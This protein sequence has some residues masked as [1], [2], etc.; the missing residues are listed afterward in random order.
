MAG[1]VVYHMRQLALV[2]GLYLKGKRN[3]FLFM[4]NMRMFPLYSGWGKSQNEF[5]IWRTTIISCK[6]RWARK[7]GC[8][9]L[10]ITHFSGFISHFKWKHES[11]LLHSRLHVRDE[12]MRLTRSPHCQLRECPCY[13][14][15]L[16]LTSTN[17]S[18]QFFCLQSRP[19]LA[20][21]ELSKFNMNVCQSKGMDSTDAPMSHMLQELKGT[22]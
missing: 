17:Y 20:K 7:S 15:L 2:L 13:S 1:S 10:A 16:V 14:S 9:T 12:I 19:V 21:P 6:K 3:W 11:H 4:W 5:C 18:H 22:S 8:Q